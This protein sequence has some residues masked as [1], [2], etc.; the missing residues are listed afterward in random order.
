MEGNTKPHHPW[1][2]SCMFL[3]CLQAEAKSAHGG[4]WKEKNSQL[5]AS[6]STGKYFKTEHIQSNNHFRINQLVRQNDFCPEQGEDLRMCLSVRRD[7]GV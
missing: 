1:L 5:L 6:E 2:N 4:W 3:K 7:K